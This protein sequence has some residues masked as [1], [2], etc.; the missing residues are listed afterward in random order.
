MRQSSLF[1]PLLLINVG[2]A[3]FLKITDN[4]PATST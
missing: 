2:A 4:Q 1:F 3:I